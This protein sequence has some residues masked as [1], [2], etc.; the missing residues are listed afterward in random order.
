MTKS[1][2]AFRT[3]SEVAEWLETPT[4]VLRFWESKFDQIKPVK[5]S[6]GR[7]YYRPKDMLLIGGIKQMLHVD[8]LTIKGAQKVLKEHGIKHVTALSQPLD[9]AEQELDPNSQAEEQVEWIDAKDLNDSAHPSQSIDQDVSQAAEQQDILTSPVSETVIEPAHTELNLA[10]VAQASE[11]SFTSDD[12]QQA[13][14]PSD[15]LTEDQIAQ[16]TEDDGAIFDGILP[17][18]A[19]NTADGR[20]ALKEGAED[21]TLQKEG[22]LDQDEAPVRKLDWDAIPAQTLNKLNN[23]NE[24]EAPE[25]REDAPTLSDLTSLGLFKDAPKGPNLTMNTPTLKIAAR[26]GKAANETET[27]AEQM[28]D[29]QAE[30]VKKRIVKSKPQVDEQ[31]T[32]N[33]WSTTEQDNLET[34]GENKPS[35]PNSEAVTPQQSTKKEVVSPNF[36]SLLKRL[37]ELTPLNQAQL[38]KLQP[39]AED[40]KSL[41]N[42]LHAK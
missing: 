40:L 38:E 19:G 17:S 25:G 12:Q 24:F 11:Q 6:G 32:L 34:R 33:F 31:P 35:A 14:T 4:H 15:R 39:F 5:R 37:S 22:T 10:D 1:A 26:E 28:R 3:I 36:T 2:E 27:H 30:A 42:R 41:Q 20:G 16:D 18:F 7:R 13:E 29:T 21:H 8:G 23:E 9:F